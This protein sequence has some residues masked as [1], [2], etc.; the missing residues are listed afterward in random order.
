MIVDID[1]SVWTK[2][3]NLLVAPLLALKETVTVQTETL[4]LNSDPQT[5]WFTLK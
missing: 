2:V 3:V 1:I 4:V 5:L